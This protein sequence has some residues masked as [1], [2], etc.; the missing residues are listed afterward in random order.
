MAS[1]GDAPGHPSK[2]QV[3]DSHPSSLGYSG[4]FGGPCGS[5]VAI[6]VSPGKLCICRF[7]LSCCS[8]QQKWGSIAP[9]GAGLV[10]VEMGPQAGRGLMSA[11]PCPLGSE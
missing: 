8:S 7:T 9:P 3:H 10:A 6:R 4:L 1:S 2:G 11:G 5:L